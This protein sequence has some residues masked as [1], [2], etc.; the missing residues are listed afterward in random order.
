MFSNFNFKKIRY[1]LEAPLVWLGIVFFRSLKIE[2]ASNL[3][4]KIAIFIGKKI[5]V[6]KLA[7][8]NLS[9]ALPHLDSSQ[10]NAV[11]NDMW[12]NLGRVIG[13]FPH[14]CKMSA[15]EILKHVEIDKNSR[16]I[17]N[18]LI[19]NNQGGIIFSAHFGNWEIGPKILI[20]YGL[21]VKTFYRPLNN[22]LVEKMTSS[23]RGVEM[24]E[25]GSEGN[26]QL[27]TALKNKEFI[28]IMADQ[29]VSDGEPI[30]FFHDNAITATAI[31]KIALKYG[32][33]LVPGFILRVN[34]QFKF[35]LKVEKPLEFNKNN[36][37]NSESSN[38]T[39][40]I[41]QT[42]EK[43]VSENP[44]QWFWVHNRWKK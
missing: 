32:V 25:K 19:A 8:N 29:K 11:I 5:A 27:I 20:N 9:K 14:V 41:N 16:V 13:E 39:L 22:P 44:E 2:N 1:V 7:M 10:K 12:D 36:S 34:K 35:L 15:D 40:K 17:L 33:P 23:L 26:R 43:W 21:K 28:L 3:S 31:A 38:L 6:N 18:E 4:G 30:K 24:I 37:L 42:I